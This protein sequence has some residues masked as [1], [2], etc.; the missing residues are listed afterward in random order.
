MF[1]LHLCG[2]LK[3]LKGS[4]LGSLDFGSASVVKRNAKR[5]LAITDISSA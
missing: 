3:H 1:L 4:W 2:K 5:A